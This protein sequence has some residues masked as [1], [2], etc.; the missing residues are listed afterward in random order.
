MQTKVVDLGT[1]RLDDVAFIVSKVVEYYERSL[2]ATNVI[3]ED[4]A[5]ILVNANRRDMTKN[6]LTFASKMRN[7]LDDPNSSYSKMT[8]YDAAMHLASAAEWY[9]KC[10][11]AANKLFVDREQTIKYIKAERKRKAERGI[12]TW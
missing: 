5:D 4:E 1:I 6:Y 7:E 3:F 12:T 10:C 2:A 9:G 11:E 8:A